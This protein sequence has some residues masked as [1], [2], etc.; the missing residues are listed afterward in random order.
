MASGQR[1]FG[2]LSRQSAP[3]VAAPES[4]DAVAPDEAPEDGSIDEHEEAAPER[5]RNGRAS[6][7]SAQPV[8]DL[9]GPE[10][11][12]SDDTPDDGSVAESA[13]SLLS[14]SLRRRRPM[15]VAA[16]PPPRR[17]APP[18]PRGLTESWDLARG[19]RAYPTPAE[20]DDATVTASGFQGVLV[21]CAEDGRFLQVRRVFGSPTQSDGNAEGG[22]PRWE[23][24][25]SAMVLEWLSTLGRETVRAGGPI[26]A[27]DVFPGRN[28]GVAWRAVI[29]P[30]STDGRGI[31]TLLCCVRME[32]GR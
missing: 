17:A 24:Q 20:I 2:R 30:L 19:S 18:R 4:V 31:D 26:D 7:L 6:R 28:G 13:A 12:D 14:I 9:D 23:E 21:R 27:R 8:A 15:T 16:P 5:D 29:L 1:T 32:T 3:P 22:A 11:I 10:A 25:N